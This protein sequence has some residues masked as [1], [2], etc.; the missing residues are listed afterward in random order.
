MTEELAPKEVTEVEEQKTHKKFNLAA[1]ISL[2]SGVLAYLL[3][4]FHSLI[5]MKA[6]LALFLAPIAAL[7]A[8]F[9]GA[10]AKRL[11]RKGDGLVTG[12]K[13]ASTGLW[14][15]WI[16]MILTV[17]LMVLAVVVFGGIVTGINQ[18]LGSIGLF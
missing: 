16:Y 15:G 9:T 11:I 4:F 14:L 6:I 13:M 3:L 17:L 1:L 12:K 10:R 2:L 5:N 18:L 8:I 7:L